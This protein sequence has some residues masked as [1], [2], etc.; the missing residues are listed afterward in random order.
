[1]KENELGS[2]WAVKSRCSKMMIL[3]VSVLESFDITSIDLLTGRGLL[4]GAFDGL[5]EG[6]AVGPA[7][8]NI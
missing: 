8:Y 1:M 4:L 7:V 3:L 2:W 5:E 6:D